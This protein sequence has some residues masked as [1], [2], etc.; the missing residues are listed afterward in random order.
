MTDD[1]FNEVAARV[2]SLIQERDEAAADAE[3]QFAGLREVALFRAA[4]T[5]GCLGQLTPYLLEELRKAREHEA[6]LTSLVREFLIHDD[7]NYGGW[8]SG[9]KH[10]ALDAI[11]ATSVDALY[12][13]GT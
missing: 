3:N 6:L 5:Q 2:A 10:R 12:P 4:N 11:L 13:E 9:M 1:E 7:R 8:T